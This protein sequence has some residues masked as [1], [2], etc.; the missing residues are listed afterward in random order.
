MGRTVIDHGC[1]NQFLFNLALAY[2]K[3]GLELDS[4]YN[5]QLHICNMEERE[6]AGRTEILWEGK[7]VH[8]L[9]YCGPSRYKHP[10]LRPPEAQT[11]HQVHQPRETVVDC[12][13]RVEAMLPSERLK[14]R[15]VKSI[16]YSLTQIVD[17]ERYLCIDA[18]MLVLEDLTPVF[19]TLDVCPSTSILVARWQGVEKFTLGEQLRGACDGKPDDLVRILEDPGQELNYP[20]VVNDGL[21]AGRKEALVMVEATLRKMKSEV[22]AWGDGH[23]MRNEF[24]FNLALARIGCAVELDGAFNIQLFAQDVNLYQDGSRIVAQWRGKPAKVLHF[25]GG[26]RNKYPQWRGRFAARHGRGSDLTA[27]LMKRSEEDKRYL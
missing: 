17:A 7:P 11:V 22:I 8:V 4:T 25:C 5:L 9:H 26:G 3:C 15:R 27:H 21:F 14:A 10:A 6:I 12:F 23:S 20:F 13:Q 18:D 2:L 24:L 19:T 1:R 16:L